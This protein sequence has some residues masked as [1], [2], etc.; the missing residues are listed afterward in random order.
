MQR[1]LQLSIWQIALVAGAC[2]AG[3]AVDE[4]AKKLD[5]LRDQYL[6]AKQQFIGAESK[7]KDARTEY[8]GAIR[9]FKDDLLPRVLKPHRDLLE[10]DGQSVGITLRSA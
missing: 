6:L 2:L 8:E 4:R 3:D 7:L 1:K 10:S 5:K 9:T